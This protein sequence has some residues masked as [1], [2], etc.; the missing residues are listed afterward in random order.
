M[1]GLSV[2]PRAGKS[3]LTNQ[4]GP[5]KITPSDI[6]S[7][8][9]EVVFGGGTPQ[10]GTVHAGHASWMT[11]MNPSTASKFK[12]P[13]PPPPAPSKWATLSVVAPGARSGRVNKTPGVKQ[14][15]FQKP[16]IHQPVSS[17]APQIHPPT[18]TSAPVGGSATTGSAPDAPPPNTNIP[19][20]DIKPDT[21]SDTVMSSPHDEVTSEVKSDLKKYL[22]DALTQTSVTSS[23]F[24]QQVSRRTSVVSEPMVQH[25][26][27]SGC[28]TEDEKQFLIKFDNGT[29]SDPYISQREHELTH[30]ALGLHNKLFEME[31]TLS[32]LG[33]I[34]KHQFETEQKK[35]VDLIQALKRENEV[36]RVE[37]HS[38]LVHNEDAQ[39]ALQK[40]IHELLDETTRLATENKLRMESEAELK[41]LRLG[42]L[43]DFEELSKLKR[44][45]AELLSSL[46]KLKEDREADG[47][48]KKESKHQSLLEQNQ[49]IA[50]MGDMEGIEMIATAVRQPI[51]PVRPANN[52]TGDA[53]MVGPAR[54]AQPKKEAPAQPQVVVKRKGE[55]HVAIKRQKTKHVRVQEVLGGGGKAIQTDVNKVR[56][57]LLQRNSKMKPKTI[58]RE[59]KKGKLLTLKEMAARAGP[60]R[61]GSARQ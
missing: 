11:V 21:S 41:E 13:M 33:P 14:A 4:T 56:S 58:G 20:P 2:K 26:K 35:L 43:K 50:G 51:A 45:H 24:S 34:Y 27:N 8:G 31:H 10:G 47:V 15:R 38:A 61:K 52:N 6:P 5:W 49:Q 12:G 54:R 28:M 53:D 57:T 55:E 46:K 25:P 19:P 18:T 40:R 23:D 60:T 48:V 17:T 39:S 42:G 30:Q 36:H 59:F 1:T 32:Q 16:M 3:G 9:S 37:R 22:V 29:Q 7:K 44:E